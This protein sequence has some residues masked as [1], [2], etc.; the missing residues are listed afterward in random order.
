MY[1][2]FIGL[3]EVADYR[4][5][6][7]GNLAEERLPNG[8]VSDYT[9]DRL[10]RLESLRTY[11]DVNANHVWD[12]AVDQLLAEYDYDLA[13]DGKRTGV[14][15]Q[16]L[17]DATLQETRIDWFYDQLGRLTCEVYDSY[18]DSLDYAADYVMD[19]VGNRLSKK[20]DSQPTAQ[21]LTDYR[22]GATM[23]TE[24]VDEAIASTFD[25]N[26]RLLREFKDVAGT[27]NDTTTLYEYG[28]NAD[29]ANGDGG[30]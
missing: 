16:Q 15:E 12:S 28:P 26:D 8:V 6:L 17:V 11:K 24:N 10:N 19:L 1:G 3:T 13:L 14:T 21:Q 25:A 5:D 7:V 9:Y 2:T 27:E 23:A 22:A 20:T 18:D 4:Y 30:D 29:P